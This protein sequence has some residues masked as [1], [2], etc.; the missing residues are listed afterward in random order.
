[1]GLLYFDRNII[2]P[3]QAAI[4]L[5]EYKKPTFQYND[6]GTLWE[7]YKMIMYGIAEQH[8]VK[9]YSQQLEVNDYIQTIYNISQMEENFDLDNLSEENEIAMVMT[10]MADEEAEIMNEDLKYKDLKDLSEEESEEELILEDCDKD[11]VNIFVESIAERELEHQLYGVDNDN[12]EVSLKVDE[13]EI[14]DTQ[15]LFTY[16]EENSTEDVEENDDNFIDN[17]LN[18]KI[19]QPSFVKFDLFNDDDDES[20]VVLNNSLCQLNS[21]QISFLHI[22]LILFLNA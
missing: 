11:D 1:M 5:K 15:N 9:W 22:Y 20:F 19:E 12:I 18:N 4:I 10:R 16:L 17:L 8:P 2:S 6:K 13:E 21:L 7:V 3:E 14:K